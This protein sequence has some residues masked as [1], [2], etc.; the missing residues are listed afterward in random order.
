MIGISTDTD[1]MRLQGLSKLGEAGD[2]RRLGHAAPVIGTLAHP[3]RR[4]V[5]LSK[6][7]QLLLQRIERRKRLV[8]RQQ[9]VKPGL[10]GVLETRARPA[11]EQRRGQPPVPRVSLLS[12]MRPE[13][14]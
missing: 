10:I 13:V 6:S 1:A 4:E 3:G 8:L 5:E 14:S 11:S 9:L 2:L 7:L 12:L